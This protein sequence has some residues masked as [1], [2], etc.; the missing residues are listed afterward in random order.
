[1]SKRKAQGGDGG[2]EKGTKK[3]RINPNNIEP[4]WT[5]IYV[6]CVRG[7]ESTCRAQMLDVLSEHTKDIETAGI[8]ATNEDDG[9]SGGDIAA[10]IAK[11]VAAL[12]QKKKNGLIVPIDVNCECVLFFR[13]KKPINPVDLVTSLCKEV[14]DSANNRCKFAQRITPVTLTASANEE[15]LRELATQVLAPHFHQEH[16]QKPLKFAIRPSLRN[17]NVMDRDDIIHTVAGIVGHDKGHKVDLKNYDKL[18]LI[19]CFRSS[20]G[21]AVVDNSFEKYSRFN[22]QQILQKSL[23]AKADH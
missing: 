6:T 4:N 9:E 22:L 15:G 5:G 21:M 16:D 20:I 23:A 8:D 1:M 14:A 2:K 17:F 12:K 13:T 3:F 7:K 18:I 10:S 19:E 11:E